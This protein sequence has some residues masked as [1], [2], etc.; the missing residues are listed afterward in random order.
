MAKHHIELE[1]NEANQVLN[2]LAL[3]PFNE[4]APLIQ[5]ISQQLQGAPPP[6]NGGGAIGKEQQAPN[7]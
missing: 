5:K 1:T 6:P 2:I 4:V 3:R 7:G